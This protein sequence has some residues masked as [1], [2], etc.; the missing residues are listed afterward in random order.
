MKLL[1]LQLSL[2]IHTSIANSVFQSNAIHFSKYINPCVYM[3][4]QNSN[5]TLSFTLR[6]GSLLFSCS[7]LPQVKCSQLH[8]Q[9]WNRWII[10]IDIDLVIGMPGQITHTYQLPP[11]RMTKAL[12]R[13]TVSSRNMEGV[14]A[15]ALNTK[16]HILGAMG[17]LTVSL[18]F[19]ITMKEL[20]FL[21]V[22]N[23]TCYVVISPSILCTL[24]KAGL[25][26]PCRT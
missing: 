14:N 25:M 3:Q 13:A 7:S 24:W 20:S 17:G 26:T 2:V 21:N 11:H 9:T 6:F 10:S 5:T 1:L 22:M 16:S 4:H 23:C 8:I 15:H 12:F 18:R 19:F